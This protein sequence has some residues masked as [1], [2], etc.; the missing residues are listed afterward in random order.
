VLWE[1]GAKQ[2]L[3]SLPDQAPTADRQLKQ[4][5]KGLDD[6][7]SRPQIQ[8]RITK[9]GTSRAKIKLDDHNGFLC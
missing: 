4:K 8:E 9:S 2:S 5:K 7:P 1:V 6:I 3:H